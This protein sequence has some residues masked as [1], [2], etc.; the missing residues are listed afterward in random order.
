MQI[1]VDS[2][3]VYIVDFE[4]QHPP[5][6]LTSGKQGAVHSPVFNSQGTK[7]AWLEL[8]KDGYESDRYILSRCESFVAQVT[9]GKNSDLRS[10]E[11]R[12]IYS[13]AKVGQVA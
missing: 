13:H 11:G 6:E 2:L 3:Q 10:G 1:T 12:K 5:R 9:Q 4:G 7:V 8:D